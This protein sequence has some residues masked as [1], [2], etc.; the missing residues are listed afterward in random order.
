MLDDGGKSGQN[1]K[2]RWRSFYEG[3]YILAGLGVGWLVLLPFFP[4]V[5]VFFGLGFAFTCYFLRDPERALP[6]DASLAVAPAD[7]LV[8]EIEEVEE[9][10]FLK[11]K[12][13]RIGIFLSVLDVHINRAPI[14]GRITHSEPKEGKFYDARNPESSLYNESRLWVI[15][16]DRVTVA[17]KQITGAI[18]RKICAWSV[19]GDVVERGARFGMIRF[20]SRTELYLPLGTEIL[21]QPGDRVRGGETPVARIPVANSPV[22]TDP[23]RQ[24]ESV[25]VGK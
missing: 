24:A 7:G 19:V 25:T 20:G 18:A 9:S 2:M 8:T 23:R 16:G 14:A 6:E 13:I 22:E 12:T 4:W 10:E 17:V 3:R 21:V 11:T 5:S 15:E 1:G